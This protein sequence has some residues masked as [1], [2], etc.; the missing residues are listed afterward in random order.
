[1][2][3]RCKCGCG[4]ELP[5][6]SQCTEMIQKKRFHG[7]DCYV[8]W[9]KAEKIRKAEQAQRKKHREQKQRIRDND[10][11]YHLKQAQAAFNAFIRERDYFENC[12]SCNATP[13]E[14]EGAQGWKPGGHWDCGHFLSVGSHPELRFEPLNAHKQCKS[15]NGG[16]GNYTRKNWQTGKDYRA[17]LEKRI[18]ADKVAWLEG[19]HDPKNYSIQDLKDITKH[20]KQAKK[21]LERQREKDL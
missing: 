8:A 21:E 19:P 20:F 15:C 11:G 3:R 18:G 7:I 17:N 2:T 16:S 14:V 1:M 13:A 5:P 12:V 6:A 9:Y 10:R 4:A